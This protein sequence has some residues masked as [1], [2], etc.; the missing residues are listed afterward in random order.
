MKKAAITRKEFERIVEETSSLLKGRLVPFTKG[1]S[2]S[3]ED[4]VKLINE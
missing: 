4:I 2:L 3:D 1:R